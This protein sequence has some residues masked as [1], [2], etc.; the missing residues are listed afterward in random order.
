MVGLLRRS[1]LCFAIAISGAAIFSSSAAAQVGDVDVLI[2]PSM[3]LETGVALARRQ[4]GETDFLG[5]AATLERILIYHPSSPAPRLLYASVL[6]R[7]DDPRGAELEVQ[8]L[9]NQPIEQ[10]AWTEVTAACG[11]LRPLPPPLADGEVR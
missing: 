6:C 1:C 8:L 4:I 5:A 11:D 9:A 10:A 3:D 7:L 2:V